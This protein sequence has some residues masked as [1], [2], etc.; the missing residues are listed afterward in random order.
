MQH[1]YQY[2]PK[3]SSGL[4][5]KSFEGKQKSACSRCDYVHWDNPLPVVAVIVPHVSGGLVLIKRGMPPRVGYWALPAG[6]IDHGEHPEFAAVRE[7]KEESGLDIK[8]A[9]LLSIHAPEG[10]N[11]ILMIYLAEPVSAL[12]SPG[13][14]ALEAKVFA[15][16]Q[17]PAEIAF[18]LHKTAIENYIKREKRNRRRRKQ[19]QG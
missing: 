18:P 6:F 12:P 10:R 9:R 5:L 8:L 11:Q 16:D 2:C 15:F 3:C 7:C 4:V 1:G 14:D 17:L 19:P 13:S